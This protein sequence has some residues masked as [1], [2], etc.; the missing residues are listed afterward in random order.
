MELVDLHKN[1]LDKLLKAHQSGTLPDNYTLEA[2]WFNILLTQNRGVVSLKQ[3]NLSYLTSD[4]SLYWFDY[5]GQYKTILA[6]LGSNSSVEQQIAQV[7]GAATLQNKTWGTIV[8]WK[9]NQAPYLD[10]RSN[11]YNQMVTSYNAGAKYITIFNYSNGTQIDLYGGAMTD[12]HFQALKNFWTQVVTKNTPNAIHA[13][14]VFVL[15]K[16]Y[17]FGMRRIDDRIWGFWGP[18]SKS[19]IIWNNMQ[20]LLS[21]YSSDLDIVYDDPA[22][23]MAAGNYSEI[24]YWNQTI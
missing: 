24:Y 21:K 4:Y 13:E 2:D 19:P 22:F 14:A 11:I 7:R 9:Y 8:T 18:D 12:A 3:Y 20:T 5:I 1:N 16:D 6:Q 17:G 23:P 10:T 15:P